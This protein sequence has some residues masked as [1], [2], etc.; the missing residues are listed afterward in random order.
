MRIVRLGVALAL[1][2]APVVSQAWW[3]EEWNF[4]KE[5]VLDLTPTGAAISGTPAEVP[6]LVRLHI[7]NFTYFADTQPDGRDFRVIAADDKTPLKF[8]IE[9]FDPQTQMAFIWVRVPQLPGGTNTDKIFLYYGNPDAPAASDP[10]G[11]FDANQVVV[12]HFAEAAGA[13]PKDTTAFG[14][15]P[16]SFTAELNPASL[17]GGGV[18]FNGSSSIQTASSPSLR[19]LPQQGATISAWVRIE[20]AQ[21]NAYVA[22]LEDQGRALILGINGTQAFA[23]LLGTAGAV[24]LLQNAGELSTGA[25]HHLAVRVGDGRLTLFVDGLDVGGTDVE[26]IE[27]AG[28]LAIGG[29]ASGGNYLAGEMD[30]F[31]FANVVRSA[32][33]LK[34]SAQSQGM[35]GRLVVYGN[36]AQ[37]DAGDVSYFAVTMRNVTVDGWV[38]IAIL[39]VMF[40]VSFVVMI[41]KGITLGRVTRENESFLTEFRKLGA[42][43]AALDKSP[44]QGEEDESAFEKS[45]ESEFM[46]AMAGTREGFQSSTLYRLYHYGVQEM[47]KRLQGQA[48]GAQRT[49]VLSPQSIEAIRATMDASLTRMTQRL[50]SQMV[51]L[52][53]SI[54]GGPFLGLLGTVV[55]VMITFAAIAA[56]G[57]VNINAIAPGIAAALAATVAGLA[58]AI[59][60]LFGYNYLSTRVKEITADNRVFVDEFITKIAEH[61]S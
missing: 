13:Q 19:V 25:W 9:R 41:A 42:D 32:D 52:T 44:A 35:D 20:E 57:D 49:A 27:I 61:Y 38:V 59:P 8:H 45:S 18:R 46:T 36:D 47:R 24:D 16:T 31:Q 30:E 10:P 53:I 60:C 17:I 58:V 55:G 34:A 39:A 22:A 37:K 1:L 29:S 3:N 5:I 11:S 2:L 51:L 26:P 50:N 15:H 21:Q 12:Y 23:R 43:A 14:N 4:R 6:V 54:A 56:S 28:L 40:V 33:W 48:A 7:G